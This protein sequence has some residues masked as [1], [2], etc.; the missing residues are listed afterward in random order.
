MKVLNT[1]IIGLGNQSVNEHI[2]A[3][4]ATD[5]YKLVALIEIRI[6][7]KEIV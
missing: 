7:R 2:P 4:L 1:I 6:Y 5:R 3:V